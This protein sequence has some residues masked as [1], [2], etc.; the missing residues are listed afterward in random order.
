MQKFNFVGNIHALLI[1]MRSHTGK[2]GFSMDVCRKMPKFIR[3]ADFSWA[4]H[5]LGSCVMRDGFFART[6]FPDQQ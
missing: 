6:H 5:L 3:R 1:D 4:N 2:N